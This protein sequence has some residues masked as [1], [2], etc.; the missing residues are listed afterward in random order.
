MR[1]LSIAFALTLLAGTAFGQETTTDRFVKV[2]NRM[3]EAINT[4]NYDGIQRDFGKEML[5]AFSLEKSTPFFKNLLTQYGKIQKLDSPR[6]V[7]PNQAIFPA[8]FE[9]GIL[10]ISLVLDNQDQIIGL[11]F[12]PPGEFPSN[13]I[14]MKIA[15]RISPFKWILW[16]LLF[17]IFNYVVIILLMIIKKRNLRAFRKDFYYHVLWLGLIPLGYILLFPETYRALS[18]SLEAIGNIVS[19]P[20]PTYLPNLSTLKAFHSSR[21]VSVLTG[22]SIILSVF[23]WTRVFRLSSNLKKID[24]WWFTRQKFTPPGIFFLMMCTLVAW[25]FLLFFINAVYG[26]YVFLKVVS[27]ATNPKFT[28]SAT[29]EIEQLSAFKNLI[30]WILGFWSVVTVG[31]VLLGYSRRKAKVTAEYDYLL[32]INAIVAAIFLVALFVYPVYSLHGILVETGDLP[33]WPISLGM[34]LMVGPNMFAVGVGLVTWV[35]R[36]T[37]R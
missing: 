12:F 16:I 30:A 17:V 34:I 22:I 28:L 24:Y 14:I 37:G 15:E 21:L 32:L 1:K 8:Y 13:D 7:P 31:V 35:E 6:I 26:H 11:L 10:H 5:D 23:G 36:L 29:R 25:S 18:G 4:A 3:V 33:T 9:R 27:Q 2:L 20:D 19:V